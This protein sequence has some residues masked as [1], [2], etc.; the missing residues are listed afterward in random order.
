MDIQKI[1]D[2]WTKIQETPKEQLH[3]QNINR[4]FGMDY[5]VKKDMETAF[6][7]DPAGLTALLLLDNFRKDFFEGSALTIEDILHNPNSAKLLEDCANLEKML[8]DP[9]IVAAL[10]EFVQ[11]TEKALDS[12]HLLKSDVC[13]MLASRYEMAILRRDALWSMET[14]HLHQFFQGDTAIEHLQYLP[15]IHMFW[16]MNSL[17]KCAWLSPDGVSL[18]FITDPLDTSSYF[19]FV[20]KNG[21]NLTIL[22]DRTPEAHPISKYMSRRPERDLTR[23]IFQHHFPYNVMDLYLNKKGDYIPSNTQLVPLQDK[24]VKVGTLSA[25]EPD[26]IIWAVMMFAL[27][28]QKLYKNNYHC[29]ELSYTSDMIAD[30]SIAQ[31]L[32]DGMGALTVKDY[33]PLQAPILTAA[34]TENDEQYTRFSGTNLRTG[35]LYERYK[36]QVPEDLMNGLL[37]N[38]AR[39][40]LL[41]DN[42]VYLADPSE[43]GRTFD[44]RE[45]LKADPSKIQKIPHEN[46]GHIVL[47]NTGPRSTIQLR[48]MTGDEFGT[49]KELMDDYRWFARHNIAAYINKKA[50]EEFAAR[51]KEV[52]QW[53]RDRAEANVHNLFKEITETALTP[54]KEI[55]RLGSCKLYIYDT[56]YHK[57]EVGRIPMKFVKCKEG[58]HPFYPH[59]N[60]RCYFTEAPCSY[61]LFCEPQNVKELAYMTGCQ[62]VEELPDVLQHWHGPYSTADDY[63]GNCILQR[64]DPMDWVCQNP[65]DELTFGMVIGVGKKHLKQLALELGV[66]IPKD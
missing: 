14:L 45:V 21:G 11:G 33:K 5:Y 62:S 54:D 25:M 18:N 32:I 57:R 10:N 38:N 36:D 26:E 40:F 65:W 13:E 66:A 44:R 8:S 56:D 43:V 24:P 6:R 34:S 35:W 47:G 39:L 55:N 9:E 27:I 2:L 60:A 31:N 22:T 4:S 12:M 42:T 17:I 16:N 20:A 30:P 53:V 49:Q 7:L 15:D 48:K 61:I 23:R 46:G 29:G 59:K 52:M 19:A 50:K 58:I 1:I 64:V 41:G 28:D 63:E 3:I 37:P 51:E